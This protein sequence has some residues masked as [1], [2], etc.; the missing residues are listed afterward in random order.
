MCGPMHRGRWMNQGGGLSRWAHLAMPLWEAN[1]PKRWGIPRDFV[2]SFGGGCCCPQLT[3]I[4]D[5]C[6]M[7]SNGDN[8]LLTLMA[9]AM[10]PCTEKLVS[11]LRCQWRN[12]S[13]G[14]YFSGWV[15]CH[16]VSYQYR[17]WGTSTERSGAVFT[18]WMPPQPTGSKYWTYVTTVAW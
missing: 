4:P 1:A 2:E 12:V 17:N 13:F 3:G 14:C 11:F 18:G 16:H 9:F 5:C 8:H 10:S 7:L 15:S 6:R